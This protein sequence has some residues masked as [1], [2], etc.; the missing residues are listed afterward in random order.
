MSEQ[1]PIHI[2]PFDRSTGSRILRLG[3]HQAVEFRNAQGYWVEFD[4]EESPTGRHWECLRWFRERVE[5]R[6]G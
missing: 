1:T 6:I 5:D 3:E 4:G 2:G